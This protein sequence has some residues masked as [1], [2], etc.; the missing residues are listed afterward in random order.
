[1]ASNIIAFRAEDGLRAAI[2]KAATF[3]GTN[4]SLLLKS[5]IVDR[6]VA[7]GFA[8]IEGITDEQ[9]QAGDSRVDESHAEPAGVE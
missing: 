2:E 4:M 5:W 1:V 3:H 6:L 8:V 7:E 9:D